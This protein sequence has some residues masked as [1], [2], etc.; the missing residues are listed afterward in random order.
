LKR[1][2]EAGRLGVVVGSATSL[3]TL[4]ADA[5]RSLAADEE[6][7]V[8]KMASLLQRQD[9]DGAKSLQR[10][11][12]YLCLA[13]GI[14]SAADDLSI[15]STALSSGSAV[16][17]PATNHDGGLCTIKVL[18]SGTTPISSVVQLTHVRFLAMGKET[19]IEFPKG[20][21]KGMDKDKGK[22]K[23]SVK[24]LHKGDAPFKGKGYGSHTT[25]KGSN[26]R[27]AA[28][29]IYVGQ[30]G[31]VQCII[32]ANTHFSLFTDA[33]KGHDFNLLGL[34]YEARSQL[35]FLSA[36]GQSELCEH[37]APFDHCLDHTATVQSVAPMTA[38]EFVTVA[39]S[40]QKVNDNLWTQGGDPYIEIDGWDMDQTMLTRLKMWRYDESDHIGSNRIYIIHGM[41][42]KHG[43]E[44]WGSSS[45]P[46]CCYRTA[47]EDVTDVAAIANWFSA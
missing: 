4:T 14:H 5:T 16:L 15:K 22:K 39:I 21:T 38:G 2:N 44:S 29:A 33:T 32:V 35:L 40:V 26:K 30:D 12:A 41:K 18:Q 46:E 36:E 34:R 31:Y 17:L 23:G 45:V 13:A 1:D 3:K 25:A 27:I 11:R 42:V 28:K 10:K 19:P 6:E 47:M 43:W 7:Y 9:Y 24:G 20:V 37:A 8:A